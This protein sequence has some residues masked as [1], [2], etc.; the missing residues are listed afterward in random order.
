MATAVVDNR[1]FSKRKNLF[2]P[3]TNRLFRNGYQHLWKEAL[4]TL[5]LCLL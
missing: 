2:I 4:G 1:T 3:T 5:L